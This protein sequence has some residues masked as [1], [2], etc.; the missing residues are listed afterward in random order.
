MEDI[1]ALR[2]E[3]ERL[4]EG[5]SRIDEGLSQR[6]DSLSNRFGLLEAHMTGRD[7][8]NPGLLI[9]IDRLEQTEK[10]SVAQMR[11]MWASISTSVIA[12]ALSLL[13]V[14]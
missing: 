1:D 9:R 11:V 2:V 5:L 6:L 14:T 13:G 4:N 10:A 7:A 8:D 3:I 12:I